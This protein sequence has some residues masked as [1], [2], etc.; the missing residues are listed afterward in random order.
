M[1]YLSRGGHVETSARSNLEYLEFLYIQIAIPRIVAPADRQAPL[2]VKLF[3][4]GVDEAKGILYSRLREQTL[5]PGYCHFPEGE[6]YE[7]EY[8][9]QLTAEKRVIRYQKGF[10]KAE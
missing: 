5:G 1:R 8:F 9:R 4:V 3:T 2:Q 6:G 7:E 10:P